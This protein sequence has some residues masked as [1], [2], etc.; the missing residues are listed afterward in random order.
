MFGWSIAC[1]HTHAHAHTHAHTHTHASI[2]YYIHV[3]VPVGCVGGVELMYT[4]THIIFEWI[5][6]VVYYITCNCRM[7]GWRTARMHMCTHTICNY[8][9]PCVTNCRLCE[10]TTAHTCTYTR[11]Y[12]VLHVPVGCVGGVQ[13]LCWWRWYQGSCLHHILLRM[14]TADTSDNGYEA[15]VRPVLGVPTK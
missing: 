12:S 4:H 11:E 5:Q 9:V 7:C 1:K 10:W 14:E 6:W 15:N 2:V 13:A 3:H 8:S